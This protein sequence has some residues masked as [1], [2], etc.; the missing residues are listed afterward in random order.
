MT[1][2]EQHLFD[3]AMRDDTEPHVLRNARGDVYRERIP[4]DF[5]QTLRGLAERFDA[6]QTAAFTYADKQPTGRFMLREMLS[7]LRISRSGA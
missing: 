4:P 1:P 2:A 6:A 7:A 3:L 5:E